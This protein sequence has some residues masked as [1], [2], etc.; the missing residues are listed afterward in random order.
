M[1]AVNLGSV[2]N[3]IV[4]DLRASYVVLHSDRQGHLVEHRR[5]AY[6]RGAFLRTIAASGHPATDYIASFPHGEQIRYPAERPGS[7][8]M[9]PAAPPSSPPRAHSESL[10][11]GK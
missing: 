8:L 1:R 7:P 5:V 4:D 3:P 2:S 6:D 11:E 10:R 9:S